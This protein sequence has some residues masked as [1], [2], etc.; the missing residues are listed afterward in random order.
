MV[1]VQGRVLEQPNVIYDPKS[2]PRRID[3]NSRWNLRGVTQMFQSGQLKNW[4]ILRITR[5]G[6]EDE[7]K[8]GDSLRSFI[9]TLRST[10]GPQSVNDPIKSEHKRVNIGNE[11]ALEQEFVK[12]KKEGVEFVITVLPDRDVA[13]YKQIKKL[14]D[15]DY[16]INTVCVVGDGKKF[17][18]PSAQQYFAN[19]ALKINLKLGGTNH[20]LQSQKALYKNTM[21]IGIDVT[22]PS[23]GPTKRTAPSVAAMVA[24]IDDQVFPSHV[25]CFLRRKTVLIWMKISLHNGQWTSGSIQRGRKWSIC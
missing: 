24:S 5:N 7:E 8:V 16:G 12:Y 6:Y 11:T 17:Y 23:P 15:V 4:V 19:V 14:G 2:P 18:K 13:L 20:V 21:V 1:N 3:D 25:H 10:L 22:H 9:G